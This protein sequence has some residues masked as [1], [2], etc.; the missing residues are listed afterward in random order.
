MPA[1]YI[2]C[3]FVG[4]FEQ[5][6]HQQSVSDYEPELGLMSIC[7]SIE[8]QSSTQILAA[9]GGACKI[10]QQITKVK[11]EFVCLPQGIVSVTRPSSQERFKS[12][13]LT[14]ISDPHDS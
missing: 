5:S 3:L 1:R 2:Q 10:V 14:S 4:H 7:K 6:L 8:S 11:G 12:F 9:G 13:L